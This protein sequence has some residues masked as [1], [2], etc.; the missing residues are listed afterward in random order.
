[1]D[2]S[3]KPW[4]DITEADYADAGD[5]CD[6]ALVNLNDGPRARWAKGQCHLPVREPR[7]MGGKVNRSALGAAAAA[8]VGARGGV[9][10]PPD[11]KRKA[12]RDLVRLYVQGGLEPPEA[13]GQLAR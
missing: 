7:A 11:V 12:A 4:G 10:L 6:A 2:L 5:C 13:L 8:L 1:M 3:L 9:N